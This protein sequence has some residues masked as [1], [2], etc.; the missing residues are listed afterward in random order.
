MSYKL[1]GRFI[2]VAT[3]LFMNSS[4]VTD[5]GVRMIGLTLNFIYMVVQSNLLI[6]PT[7]VMIVGAPVV[8]LHG[9]M[10]KTSEQE[11]HQSFYQ[12]YTFLILPQPET[13]H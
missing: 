2:K 6:P 4:R 11:H 10:C 5:Q 8:V 3:L 12:E 7:S 9:L 13:S 1:V